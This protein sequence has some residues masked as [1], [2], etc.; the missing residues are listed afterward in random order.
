M[1]RSI[2]TGLASLFI[3]GASVRNSS[4]SKDLEQKQQTKGPTRQTIE[5]EQQVQ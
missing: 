1:F 5:S 4:I 2:S 3:P